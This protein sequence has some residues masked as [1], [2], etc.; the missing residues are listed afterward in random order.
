M[1]KQLLFVMLVLLTKVAQ[2]QDITECSLSA[3]FSYTISGE[4][5]NLT[6][7]NLLG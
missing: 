1:G 7:N 2:A 5:I 6:K 4:T 3:N